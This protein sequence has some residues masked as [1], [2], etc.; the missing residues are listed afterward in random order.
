MRSEVFGVLNERVQQK[1]GKDVPM[2][3]ISRKT[4]STEAPGR[5]TKAVGAERGIHADEV[6]RKRIPREVHP[7]AEFAGSGFFISPRFGASDRNAELRLTNPQT[8]VDRADVASPAAGVCRQQNLSA[9]V[10]ELG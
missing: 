2:D 9:E 10:L 3:G 5:T 7:V 8:C 6:T 1:W 4:M